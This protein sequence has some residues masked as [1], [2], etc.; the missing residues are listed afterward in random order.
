MQQPM[1]EQSDS[2]AELSDNLAGSILPIIS[3]YADDVKEHLVNSPKQ[4]AELINNWTWDGKYFNVFKD[5]IEEFEKTNES[6]KKLSDTL[7]D[8]SETL[9][10]M[11]TAYFILSGFEILDQTKNMDQQMDEAM[12][13][14][15]S[16]SKEHSL[17]PE[18]ARAA[19]DTQYALLKSQ[20]AFSMS[21]VTSNAYNKLI[22]DF[23]LDALGTAT[24]WYRR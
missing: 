16:A 19:L 23:A 9:G 24:L 7:S 13:R 5:S 8:G 22:P 20:I 18:T 14:Y 15:I 3:V 4:L 1:E 10:T 11:T 6:Y 17:M 21:E 2:I 12:D